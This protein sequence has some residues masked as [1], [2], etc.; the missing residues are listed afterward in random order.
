MRCCGSESRSGHPR[1]QV[2]SQDN[3]R[4][5][6]ICTGHRL[7]TSWSLEVEEGVVNNLGVAMAS[8]LVNRLE[9]SSNFFYM[10][11][12]LENENKILYQARREAR[13]RQEFAAPPGLY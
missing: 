5:V 13:E 4:A 9:P 12:I 6:C 11:S 1:S 3:C 2:A 10:V 8:D 7:G